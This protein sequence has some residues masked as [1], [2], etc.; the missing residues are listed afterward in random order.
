M[1]EYHD[2]ILLFNLTNDSIWNKA[3][4]DTL[5]LFAYYNKNKKNYLWKDRAQ[6]VYCEMPDTLFKKF[7]TKFIIKNLSQKN[8]N[9]IQKY[10]VKMT[11]LNV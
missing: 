8:K 3:M 7:N 9:E 1:N 6:V 11:I 5:G 10:F 4:Q 2:G